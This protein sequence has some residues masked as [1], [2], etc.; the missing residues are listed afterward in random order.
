MAKLSRFK[1]RLSWPLKWLREFRAARGLGRGRCR[2]PQLEVIELENRAT[3][4]ANSLGW[5]ALDFHWIIEQQRLSAQNDF[6]LC[7]FTANANAVAGKRYEIDFA[8][9]GVVEPPRHELIFVDAGIADLDAFV[10]Q[11][12]EG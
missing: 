1:N 5:D 10:C 7:R 12:E 2:R 9:L 11:I 6:H 4:S 3:P 8:G